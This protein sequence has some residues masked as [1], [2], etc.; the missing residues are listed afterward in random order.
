[1]SSDDALPWGASTE[2]LTALPLTFG[3]SPLEPTHQLRCF[4]LG[5][6]DGRQDAGHINASGTSR[7]FLESALVCFDC[8]AE[9][10]KPESLNSA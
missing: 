1:M 2:V 7:F 3:F 10:G 4:Q 5:S 6:R 9:K 8:L